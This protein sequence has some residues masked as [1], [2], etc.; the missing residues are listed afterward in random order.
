MPG[1]TKCCTCHAKSSSQNW[2]SDAPKCNNQR[3]DLLISLP[4]A[5]SIPQLPKLVRE[6]CAS[7]HLTW[8][9]AS[10]HNGVQFLISH[11]ARCRNCITLHY[12]TTLITSNYTILHY[13]RLDYTHTHYTTLHYTNYSYK[14]TLTITTNCTNNNYNYSY[15][16]HYTTLHY[17]T[18]HYTRLHY[19]RL[20]YSTQHYGT[21]HYT[22]LHYA[23]LITPHHNYNNN[24]TTLITPHYNYNATT[25]QLQLRLR[26]TTLYP[27]VVGE[28]T[29]ATIAT[30]P[31][32]QLQPPFGPSVDSLCHPESMH[33]NNSPLL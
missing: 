18:L 32:T 20:H 13:T 4:C 23:T 14:T 24:Y 27:A 6:W 10:R 22:T 17:T 21:L 29:A 28:V 11:L 5:F 25:L 16:Y 15:S 3:P 31:K 1:H 2:R 26:Y 7:Y 9:C 19:T 12:Y 8:K 30:T 33:H